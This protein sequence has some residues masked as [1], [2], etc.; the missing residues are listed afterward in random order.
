LNFHFQ[1][2]VAR[3]SQQ[4]NGTSKNAAM[5]LEPTAPFFSS[6]FIQQK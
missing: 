2:I 4:K 3:V 5:A 1:T 6:N